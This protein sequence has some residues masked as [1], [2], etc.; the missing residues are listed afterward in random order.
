MSFKTTGILALLLALLGGYIYLFEIR[1][2]EEKERAEEAA[3]KIT[4]VTKET[5]SQLR[6]DAF[7]ESVFAVKDG[8][9]W[10]IVSPVETEGDYEALEGLIEAAG[11]LEKVGVAADS[12]QTSLPDFSLADFGLASPA[13]RLSFTVDDGER[14]EVAF[15][16]RSPTGIYFYVKTD[17]DDRIY[18][19][20]S[21]FYFRFELSLLDL[22]DKRYV[23][24]DLDRLR[25]I[26]LAYGSSKVAVERDGIH[27][28][29]TAPVVDAGDDVG[30]GRFLTALRNARIETFSAL[31]ND[32]ETGLNE[33][34][35]S[36]RLDEGG[37]RGLRGIAFGR[38]A[39]SRAYR[40]YLARSFGTPHVFEAD[41]AFVHQL[42]SAGDSFRTRDVFTFNRHEVDRV[43]MAFPDSS[44]IFDKQGPEQWD[45]TS[46]PN[47]QVV[48]SKIEDFIDEVV[49]LRATS[50]VAEAM[51][52]DRRAV[53]ETNGIRI[54]LLGHGKLIRE[55]VV[56]AL[57]NL[58][59]AATND[60]QQILEIENY[61]MGKIRDV[62]IYPKPSVTQG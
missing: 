17:G 42:I 32:A 36:I 52:D 3:R 16:D 29:M 24:V 8:F 25:G 47:H 62:R 6:L 59:F 54:R 33:P 11:S 61:F 56:G 48:G 21:R 14:Q 43:E 30:I 26:E 31:T 45:V 57:G 18:L 35:F 7:G 23:W 1:G 22:R 53:F 46:H 39:G 41:S 51:E 55:V 49:A 9:S 20:E 34:W 2:W 10:K 38:K 12:S 50:Y 60:R 58:L 27:W 5:V 40:T 28:R 37:D 19:A 13:I 15:G 44:M 4:Q